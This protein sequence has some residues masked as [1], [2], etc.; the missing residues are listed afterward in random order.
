[1]VLVVLFIVFSISNIISQT[2]A[3]VEYF[4]NSI[5]YDSD[6]CGNST[7]PCGTLYQTSILVNLQPQRLPYRDSKINVI[8][9]QNQNEILKY[10]TL[11]NRNKYNPCFPQPFDSWKQIEISF[12]G[13][14]RSEE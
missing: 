12:I 14:I 7:H 3:I 10:Y 13:N 9:G 1:M 5:G 11:N 8:N 4:V 2:H 6:H